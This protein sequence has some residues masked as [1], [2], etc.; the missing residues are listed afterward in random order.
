MSNTIERL[1]DQ[2]SLFFIKE[3]YCYFVI[4]DVYSYYRKGDIMD[5]LI[6][7]EKASQARDIANAIFDKGRPKGDLVK[8]GLGGNHLSSRFSGEVYVTRFQGHVVEM[9]WPSE[10]DAKYDRKPEEDEWGFS[11]FIG[12]KVPPQEMYDKYPIEL[13]VKSDD[14]LISVKKKKGKETPDPQMKKIA[15]NVYRLFKQAKHVVIAT[16]GDPEGEMIFRNWAKVYLGSRYQIPESKLYRVI[17]SST[18]VTSINKAFDTTLQ[19]YDQMKGKVG[20]FYETLFPQGIARGIADYEFGLSYA[21]YGEHLAQLNNVPY[22]LQTGVWGRL[23]NTILG[24]V[25]QAEEAHDHFVPSSTYRVD[26]K[27]QNGVLLKSNQVFDTKEEGT[28]FLK[29][30][31]LPK[32][33]VLTGKRSQTKQVPPA[34]YSRTELMVALNKVNSRKD[35]NPILQRLYE[36]KKILSY[37][38][39]DSQHI[40]QLEWDGLKRYFEIP[41]V[42][43]LV[44]QFIALN[45]KEAS[46]YQV[47]LDR[48]PLKKWVDDQKTVPHYALIPNFEVPLSE[49][50]YNHLDDD[51]KTV[52][53]L[54][55]KQSMALFLSDTV[56]EKI[57]IAHIEGDVTFKDTYQVVKEQGWRLLTGDLAKDTKV[58]DMGPQKVSYVLTEVPAK[59][60][61]LL[62]V[63]SLLKLLKRRGEGTSATRDKTVEELLNGKRSIRQDRKGGLRLQDDL[64]PVVALMLDQHWINMDQTAEWQ[65]TLNQI[66]NVDDAHAFIHQVRQDT[67]AIHQ[68]IR[69]HTGGV[70]NG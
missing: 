41:I 38:R 49:V 36:T 52:F 32:E 20:Q 28:T 47:V 40:T 43:E 17:I 53:D 27:T 16:D 70:S 21:L 65:K 64:K 13:K 33:V 24:H 1:P 6:I 66:N 15:D 23:K 8:G 7:A 42:R 48:E 19:R 56:L 57:D 46:D 35:W 39:T 68:S 58:P 63:G 61:S 45:N 22:K 67:R 50:I 31:S 2:G 25:Y 54:D 59:Q 44:G 62:T 10:Q 55:L 37:P 14:I 34:L 51:E 60:P 29:K 4:N 26:M 30:A 18:D 9:D 5:W 69:R 3:L 12:T 11:D